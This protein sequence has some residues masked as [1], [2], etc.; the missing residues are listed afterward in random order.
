[1]GEGGFFLV[2]FSFSS[3]RLAHLI[4]AEIHLTSA[5]RG[6]RLAAAHKKKTTC[7]KV[8]QKLEHVGSSVVAQRRKVM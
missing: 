4:I 8:V 5:A 1:M 6:G 7:Q 3:S 2:F